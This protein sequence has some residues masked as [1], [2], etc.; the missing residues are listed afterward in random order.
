M[1]IRKLCIYIFIILLFLAGCK[2]STADTEKPQE[3]APKKLSIVVS[4]Y[5]AYD[6]VMQVLG[7]MT[8]TAEVTLLADNGVD[9][10]S[11]QPSMD[12]IIR[13]SECDLFIYTGGVS[14]TWVRD[15]LREAVNQDM[16]VIS[17]M[18]ALGD[19]VQDEELVEGMEDSDE[20][21][22]GSDASDDHA[23]DADNGPEYDEHV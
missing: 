20:D 1:K 6:W 4:I 2:G 5:P 23:P 3:A 11:Y 16:F 8:D 7:E 9:L 22:H 14:D 17:L 13:I 21:A 10:H 18:E 12:D 19:A 15:A